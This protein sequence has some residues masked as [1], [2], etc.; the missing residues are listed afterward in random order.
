MHIYSGEEHFLQ[1]IFLYKESKKVNSDRLAEWKNC[2]LRSLLDLGVRLIWE[3]L[4][5]GFS[6]GRAK[7]FRILERKRRSETKNPSRSSLTPGECGDMSIPCHPAVML[8][9]F[10]FS[11]T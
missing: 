3:C 8:R 10:M 9:G 6:D 4:S 7:A 5:K 1:K 2:R 11:C